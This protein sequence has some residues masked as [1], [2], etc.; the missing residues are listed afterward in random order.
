MLPRDG[1]H[2]TMSCHTSGDK[3]HAAEQG[4]EADEGSI[5]AIVSNTPA[6]KRSLCIAEVR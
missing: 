2:V 5:V 4:D 6:E 3:S 1:G